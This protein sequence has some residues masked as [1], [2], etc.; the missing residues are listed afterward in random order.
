MPLEAS[1]TLWSLMGHCGQSWETPLRCGLST[2]VL[3]LAIGPPPSLLLA[4]SQDIR[5]LR[6]DGTDY[7]TLFSQQGG[8]ILALDYDPVENK[9]HAAH[10]LVWRWV[11]KRTRQSV[12][13][14]EVPAKL[15]KFRKQCSP[16]LRAFLS[17]SPS[18]VLAGTLW[19]LPSLCSPSGC[20]SHRATCCVT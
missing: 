20:G 7:R 13:F 15:R 4:N 9:V 16:T 11:C 3:E 6:F 2:D 1:V 14:L 5:H 17:P 10:Q 12:D 8:G 18:V 19:F